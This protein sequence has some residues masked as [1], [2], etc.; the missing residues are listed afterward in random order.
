MD[1]VTVCNLTVRFGK[2]EA[3]KDVSF[4][5]K[6]GD[7]LN[8]IGPNGSGKT[9]LIEV[10]TNLTTPS[11]GSI[12]IN[13]KKVGYLPQKLQTKKNFPI[14]VKEVIYGG[15][16]K[17]EKESTD[18]EIKKWLEIMNIS[19]LINENMSILSG[20]Q[21]Q[22]V[23]IIRALISNPDLLI[24]DEPTS[25][26]DP[27]FREGFYLFLNSLQKERNMTIINVTH[28]LSDT[29][30]DN[31]LILYIDQEVKFFGESKEFKEFEHRGHKHV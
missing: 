3:L 12:T 27:E 5:L 31:S 17:I 30:K 28:D 11:S 8:V 15:L 23:Y 10:L 7:F 6:K 2:Y 13:E 9:T 16:D 29:L 4:S 1:S 24:L 14:T 20:G 25:A 22:R 18:N 26:L 19:H 21:Q